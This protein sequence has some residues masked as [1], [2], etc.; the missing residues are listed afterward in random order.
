MTE[1]VKTKMIIDL[2]EGRTKSLQEEVDG[3]KERIKQMEREFVRRPYKK[4]SP[5]D[6]NK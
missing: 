1:D 5:Y 6:L 4:R 2:I 3:L